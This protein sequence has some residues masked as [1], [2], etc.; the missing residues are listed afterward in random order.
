KGSSDSMI[1]VK[2][3][4]STNMIHERAESGVLPGPRSLPIPTISRILA[5]IRLMNEPIDLL[6]THH[7][8]YGELSGLV[9][10]KPQRAGVVM[11]FGP[12][13]NQQ[14]LSDPTLFYAIDAQKALGD[15][16]LARLSAG[17]V[18]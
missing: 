5:M 4:M 2:Q 3:R 18:N 12:R 16:A 17:L 1:G 9:A 13:Y 11:A 6:R 14:V 8:R 7:A 10:F 15:N